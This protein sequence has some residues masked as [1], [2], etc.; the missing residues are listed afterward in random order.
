M[1]GALAE[2]AGL[3]GNIPDLALHYLQDYELLM[4]AVRRWPAASAA[5]HRHAV[6]LL[7]ENA[8]RSD[9]VASIAIEQDA[10]MQEDRAGIETVQAQY[11]DYAREF[12]RR[13][14]GWCRAETAL[15]DQHREVMRAAPAGAIMTREQ[16]VTASERLLRPY[17]IPESVPI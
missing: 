14:A 7:R 12:G 11:G 2:V 9:V 1:I 17:R 3:D 15:T 8:P 6:R 13:G 5:C 4:R 16:I 10:R